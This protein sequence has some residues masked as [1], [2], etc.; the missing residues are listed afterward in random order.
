MDLIEWPKQL[1]ASPKH[2]YASSVLLITDCYNKYITAYLLK[3]NMAW[4]LVH[5]IHNYIGNNGKMDAILSDNGA[6][7][8]N[9][10]LN[11]FLKNLEIKKLVSSPYIS[12][13]RGSIKVLVCYIRQTFRTSLLDTTL[14]MVYAIPSIVRL[15]NHIPIVGKLTPHHLFRGGELTLKP[16]F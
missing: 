10:H 16:L 5:C 11:T 13:A 14:D 8:S 6:I 2:L 4:E 9:K 12:G 3:T 1:A 15:K 7:F